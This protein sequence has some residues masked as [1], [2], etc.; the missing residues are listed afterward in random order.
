ML[1]KAKLHEGKLNGT[2]TMESDVYKKS[3]NRAMLIAFIAICVII[4]IF[5][6]V[7]GFFGE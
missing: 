5:V 1:K 7:F 4:L 6:V 2:L 3:A